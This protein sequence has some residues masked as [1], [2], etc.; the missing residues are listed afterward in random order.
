M[1]F[2]GVPWTLNFIISY[3]WGKR[4]HRDIETSAI[5]ARC[6]LLGNKSHHSLYDIWEVLYKQ[7]PVLKVTSFTYIKTFATWKHTKALDSK[8]LCQHPA[9]NKFSVLDGRTQFPMKN[10]GEEHNRDQFQRPSRSRNGDGLDPTSI[11]R[12]ALNWNP[13]GKRRRGRPTTT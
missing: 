8:P 7:C 4:L 3:R 2:Q 9:Y 13:Q 5:S 6:Q 12:Q 11:T 1:V 10:T